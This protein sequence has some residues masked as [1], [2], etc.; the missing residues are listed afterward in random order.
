MADMDRLEHAGHGA[1]GAEPARAFI[2]FG[3]PSLGE[4]EERAVLEVLRSGWI[5][6]GPRCLAFERAFAEYVGAAHAVAVSSCTAA[7]HLALL[8]ARVGPGDEVITTPLTFAATLNAILYTG[9]RPVLVDVAAGTGNLDPEQV[10]RAATPRTKAILAVHFAGLPCDLD[11]LPRIA[12]R[13]GLALVEDAAHAVGAEWRGRRIGG[14]PNSI[15][16]FSFY[17][18][19]NIT[20]GE[21]GMLTLDAADSARLAEGLRLHGLDSDAWGRYRAGASLTP[22]QV[23]ALGYKYNM[24]DVQAAIGLV[25]LARIEQFLATRESNARTLDEA[26]RGLPVR[27]PQETRPH[28][29]ALHLYNLVLD[30]ERLDASRDEIVA[31][32]RAAG[33]GATVHY[34]PV[35]LHPYFRRTLG[36]GPGSF[37]AAEELGNSILTLPVQPKLTADDLAHVATTARA[38]IGRHCR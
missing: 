21:G 27:R 36:H 26:F 31:E 32:I 6:M 15:A 16:C 24:T 38:V 18:N 33:V 7:L 35:H 4:E 17:P 5:G 19:K 1:F 34:L 25:Q 9:A 29:H 28:R 2:P 12:E 11:A 3:E 37:P 23:E 10:E 14:T 30:L 20:S 13:R 22:S 8:A